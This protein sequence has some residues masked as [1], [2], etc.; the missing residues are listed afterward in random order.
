MM[1]VTLQCLYLQISSPAD[2]RS[3]LQT[4]YV[5]F[6]TKWCRIF[7]GP[8]WNHVL[9]EQTTIAVLHSR[10][11]N[12]IEVRQ[13]IM[14]ELVRLLNIQLHNLNLQD[15]YGS[16]IALTLSLHACMFVYMPFNSLL[17]MFSSLY[18]ALVNVP[19]LS[20]RTLR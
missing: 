11:K 1:C 19:A 18:Q 9:V 2:Y 16:S 17:M 20:E 15:I 7:T 14:C 4:M 6:G 5:F 12:P 10:A 3:W 8:L 13:C